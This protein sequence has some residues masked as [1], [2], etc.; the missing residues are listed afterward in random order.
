[1]RATEITLRIAGVAMYIREFSVH[2]ELRETIIN[3]SGVLTIN[4]AR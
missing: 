3:P 1:M 2:I 4:L